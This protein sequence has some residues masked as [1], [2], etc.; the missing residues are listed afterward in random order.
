MNNY[1]M[2]NYLSENIKNLR[3]KK[4][5]TQEELSN[6]LNISFQTISKWERGES[7]PDINMVIALANYFDVST[8]ELL[9][10]DKHKS[11]FFSYDYYKEISELIKE[12]KY[13]EAVN[14]YREA[15]KIYPN[16][17]GINAGLAMALAL[18]NKSSDWD[19]AAELCRRILGDLQYEKVKAS[20]R[21]VLF[22]IMKKTMPQEEAL[23][24]VKQLTHIWE[25]REMIT[26]ELYE[27]EER[28]K[29]LKGS[30][31]LVISLLYNK[32]KNGKS[33]DMELLRMIYL[34]PQN[35]EDNKEAILKMLEEIKKFIIN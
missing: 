23:K 24:N 30:V 22:I 11:D 27:G 5:I 6:Y 1:I 21:T 14:R 16:N 33:N 17:T 32:I 12:E 10:M 25:S 15:Q 19:E 34:G 26:S 2:N 35:I 9:G 18:R 20:L 3:R 28:V 31:P 13:D 8:D 29:Y 4:G 7:L